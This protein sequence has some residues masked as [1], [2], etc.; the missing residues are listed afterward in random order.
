MRLFFYTSQQRV[1][2]ASSAEHMKLLAVECSNADTN[3][4]QLDKLRMIYEEYVKLGKE[5]IPLA[6]KTLN[7]LMEE[8]NQKTQAF[9][10]VNVCL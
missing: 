8:L 5:T 2:S 9:D 10:D 1:K 6:E 7:E 3:F 4:Q